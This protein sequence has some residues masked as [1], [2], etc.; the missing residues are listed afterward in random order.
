MDNMKLCKE[1]NEVKNM[2]NDFY[3]SGKGFQTYCKKCSNK[4]RTQ[5]P[6]KSYYVKRAYG[7]NKLD[8]ETKKN[9]LYDLSIKLS[10]KEVAEKYNIKYQTF[11]LWNRRGEI[12][13]LD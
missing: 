10:C 13:P 4:K 7:F 12:K 11:C 8:D 5:Y 1:C 2:E 9:I 6:I 3:K